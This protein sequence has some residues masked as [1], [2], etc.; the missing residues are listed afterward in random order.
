MDTLHKSAPEPTTWPNG[1]TVPDSDLYLKLPYQ[2]SFLQSS[3]TSD[4]SILLPTLLTVR[5]CGGHDGFGLLYSPAQDF[6]TAWKLWDCNTL[7]C[8]FFNFEEEEE[9][10]GLIHVGTLQC[11]GKEFRGH[12]VKK[13]RKDKKETNQAIF[14]GCTMDIFKESSIPYD[15]KVNYSLFLCWMGKEKCIAKNR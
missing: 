14:K 8:Y 7:I 6:P 5:V 2:A 13:E 15:A 11:G 12:R 9:G 3:A 1:W 4:V 10:E